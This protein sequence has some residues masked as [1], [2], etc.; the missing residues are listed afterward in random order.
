MR[1]KIGWIRAVVIGV[2]YGFWLGAG[3]AMVGE[4]VECSGETFTLV[5]L[6]TI[7]FYLVA[8]FIMGYTVGRTAGE[9][10]EIVQI[11]Q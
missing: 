11:S 2:Y 8:P 1:P 5:D 3:L 10:N 4:P 9:E 6:A 7:M